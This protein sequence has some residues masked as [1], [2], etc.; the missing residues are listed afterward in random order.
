MLR[1]YRKL[2]VIAFGCVLSAV[3]N[4]E[5]NVETPTRKFTAN[6]TL[7]SAIG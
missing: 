7:H 4:A 6:L 1:G 2:F 3:I 5:T